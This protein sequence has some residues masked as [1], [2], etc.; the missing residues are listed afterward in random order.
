MSILLEEMTCSWPSK[1]AIKIVK[2]LGSRKS[3]FM[4][5]GKGEHT[6]KLEDHL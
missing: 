5:L 1:A 2:Y 6:A 3:S 4:R